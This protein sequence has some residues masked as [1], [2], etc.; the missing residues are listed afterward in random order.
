MAQTL[1]L[2]YS[3]DAESGHVIRVSVTVVPRHFFSR[4]LEKS[5][6]DFCSTESLV[7]ESESHTGTSDQW[8]IGHMLALP[9]RLVNQVSSI[10]CSVVWL[11]R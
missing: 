5:L 4:P 3:L 10:Y 7:S 11:H 9:K 2:T 1:Q 8:G 6:L